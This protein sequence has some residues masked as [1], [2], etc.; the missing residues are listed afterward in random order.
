MWIGG[1][2]SGALLGPSGFSVSKI[3][4]F[5]AIRCDSEAPE[6]NLGAAPPGP[7][8]GGV[9]QP[10]RSRRTKRVTYVNGH[11]TVMQ[12]PCGRHAIFHD[13]HAIF[14]DGHGNSMTIFHDGP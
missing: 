6:F 9:L 10:S 8:V 4:R 1:F 14:H 12:I 13:G 2:Q 7:C 5:L 11:G 3:P